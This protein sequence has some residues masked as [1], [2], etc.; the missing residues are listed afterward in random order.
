MWTVAPRV[1]EPL[2]QQDSSAKSAAD[3]QRVATVTR[4]LTAAIEN[5]QS[6]MPL[7]TQAVSPGGHASLRRLNP[8]LH[9]SILESL[10]HQEHVYQFWVDVARRGD[11]DAVA[12][13]HARTT[14]STEL[15]KVFDRT[16]ANLYRTQGLG[17]REGKTGGLFDA[18]CG[19]VRKGELAAVITRKNFMPSGVGQA[20]ELRSAL[21]ALTFVQDGKINI[22][23]AVNL[24]AS[25]LANTEEAGMTVDAAALLAR[26]EARIALSS[27][28]SLSLYT[29]SGEPTTWS[30]WAA[31]RARHLASRGSALVKV[32]E[33]HDVLGQLTAFGV[34]QS[35][36]ESAK[37]QV[38]ANGEPQRG[39]G[40]D[41]GNEDRGFGG[42]G[43]RVNAFE[44]SHS[45]G[46]GGWS[47]GG[48]WVGALE[49]AGRNSSLYCTTPSCG[50]ATKPY[51]GF[52][53]LGHR[54]PGFVNCGSCGLL[55]TAKN[56]KCA[57]ALTHGCPGT[58]AGYKP[59]SPEVAA[60]QSALVA[61][62]WKERLQDG[63][64]PRF[65]KAPF[66][67]LLGEACGDGGS[68]NPYE[69]EGAGRGQQQ[70][71]AGHQLQLRGVMN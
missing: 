31:Q 46:T 50:Q 32:E 37:N 28:E 71:A 25:A 5:L 68:G 30:L 16:C 53:Q 54:Q 34:I 45:S 63:N 61:G 22:P 18:L 47:A 40:G 13:G 8:Q 44:T 11:E 20:T 27:S 17:A 12:N 57:R 33:V 48:A 14:L 66:V 56:P 23:G 69:D 1:G 35:G 21:D 60:A 59:P 36:Q 51:F 49:G 6:R 15:G 55:T 7:T 58:E 67:G 2:K 64:R 41:A 39:Y 70:P 10:Q 38:I 65:Q 42:G 26:I 3:A 9:L 29:P 43:A 24:L 4:A 19:I 62:M 52:C